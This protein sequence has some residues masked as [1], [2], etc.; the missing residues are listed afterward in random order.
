MSLIN[1][2]CNLL[3][4]H[5]FLLVTME[6]KFNVLKKQK[7]YKIG[8]IDQAIKEYLKIINDFKNEA[9]VYFLIGTAFLQIKDYKKC[10]F[11]FIESYYI[12]KDTESYYNNIGIALSQLIIMRVQ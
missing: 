2:F 1:I 8:K 4:D 9:Q 11:Y 5:K 6:N 7:N 3:L 10:V 12:K